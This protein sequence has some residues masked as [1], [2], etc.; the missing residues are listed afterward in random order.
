MW[1]FPT[2][3]T[4]NVFS[5]VVFHVILMLLSSHVNINSKCNTFE[6]MALHVKFK[7]N[8]RGEREKEGEIGHG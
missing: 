8:I 2:C 3:E 5:C 4:A 7:V 1:S 6:N